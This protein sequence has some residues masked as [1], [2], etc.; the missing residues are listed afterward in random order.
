MAT[1]N[2]CS[3]PRC[4]FIFQK[5]FLP[6][7]VRKKCV[8][9]YPRG[10]FSSGGNEKAFFYRDYL[11]RKENNIFPLLPEMRREKIKTFFSPKFW[12]CHVCGVKMMCEVDTICPKWGLIKDYVFFTISL[13]TNR[14]KTERILLA[15]KGQIFFQRKG[16]NLDILL[17]EQVILVYKAV[18]EFAASDKKYTFYIRIINYWFCHFWPN[19]HN[20]LVSDASDSPAVGIW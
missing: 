10:R 7:N 9:F 2:Y 1:I 4:C 17:I 5:S 20:L 14:I 18:N 12:K 11:M 8:L 19:I 3:L 6:Q 16:F 15:Q 13:E